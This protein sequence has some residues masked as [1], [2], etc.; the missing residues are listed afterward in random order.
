MAKF[1]L[2]VLVKLKNIITI[3]ITNFAHQYD[4][5]IS[6]SVAVGSHDLCGPCCSFSWSSR[7]LTPPMEA[8]VT[9]FI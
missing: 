1:N 8:W 2:T 7:T 3:G 5:F 6:I 4:G 9:M